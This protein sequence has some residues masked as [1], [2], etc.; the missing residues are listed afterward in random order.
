MLLCSQ[1]FSRASY[2]QIRIRNLKSIAGLQQRTN[3]RLAVLATAP[4]DQKA[5]SRERAPSNPA[6][7]LVEL[8][9]AK[10]LRVLDDHQGGIGNIDTHFN[11]RRRYEYLR[12]CPLKTSHRLVSS[13]SVESAMN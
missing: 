9:Q 8:R 13:G 7:Q 3:T 2:T 12:F 6:P 1:E 5:G 10:T 11:D 4:R